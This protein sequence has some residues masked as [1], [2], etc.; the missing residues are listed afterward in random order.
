MLIENE[1]GYNTELC[2]WEVSCCLSIGL[3]LG[4]TKYIKNKNSF[5]YPETSQ[6]SLS[7]YILE[8]ETEGIEPQV[9]WKIIDRGKP[10]SPV[11]GVCH[12]CLKEKFYMLYNPEMASLNS[13][14]KIFNSCRHNRSVLLFKIG[15]RKKESENKSPGS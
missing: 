8:L 5:K 14:N 1:D 3:G 10:F 7:K 12:L 6:T 2:E 13:G 4:V 11:A 15:R 9:T